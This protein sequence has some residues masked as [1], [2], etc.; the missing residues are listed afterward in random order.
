MEIHIPLS[1]WMHWAT[2]LNHL[3]YYCFVL[4]ILANLNFLICKLVSKMHNK[5][6]GKQILSITDK[7]N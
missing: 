1:F 2:K 6:Y 4:G 5:I 7:T 3:V